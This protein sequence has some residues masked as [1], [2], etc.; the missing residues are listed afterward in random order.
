MQWSHLPRE[1]SF[2]GPPPKSVHVDGPSKMLLDTDLDFSCK[3]S[4]S[5][6]PAKLSWRVVVPGNAFHLGKGGF[7][8]ELPDGSSESKIV[9]S[10]G[11]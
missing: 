2:L 4:P 11:N 8:A 6:P 1:K 7:E 3:A 5:H 9:I 10:P